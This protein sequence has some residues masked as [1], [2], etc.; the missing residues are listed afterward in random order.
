MARV[1]AADNSFTDEYAVFGEYRAVGV[2]RENAEK[3][4]PRY[5]SDQHQLPRFYLLPIARSQPI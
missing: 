4:R 1:R 2:F 3:Q 5:S